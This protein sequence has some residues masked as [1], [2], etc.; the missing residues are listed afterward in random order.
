ML[1]IV[2]EDSRWAFFEIKVEVE[3]EI[4]IE[5]SGRRRDGNFMAVGV[6]SVDVIGLFRGDLHLW[7]R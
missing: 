3:I 2:L 1:C 4:E 5:I 6:I 7:G